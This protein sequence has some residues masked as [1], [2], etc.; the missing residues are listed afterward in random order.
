MTAINWLLHTPLGHGLAISLSS[1]LAGLIF[2]DVVQMIVG[3]IS[4]EVEVALMDND[5]D[6]REL[7][8]ALIKWADKKLGP[9][10]QDEKA[11]MI[12]DKVI[13]MFPQMSFAHDSLIKAI[14]EFAKAEKESLESKIGK[15]GS[16]EHNG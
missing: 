15:E 4:K 9:L 1:L 16:L 3:N 10:E 14:E 5:A 6:D 11:A 2:R 13:T 7:F 8:L 12:V